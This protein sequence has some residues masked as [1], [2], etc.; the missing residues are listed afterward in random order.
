M[1]ELEQ[2]IVDALSSANDD[3]V[4]ESEMSRC[5]W[6]EYKGVSFDAYIVFD[7]K[8]VD[9]EQQF[10]WGW[11]VTG[12]HTEYGSITKIEVNC[13]DEEKDEDLSG[14]VDV[15]VIERNIRLL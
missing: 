12:W 11:S 6:G 1:N 3:E 10:D 2:H 14:L 5:V 4:S 8:K 15:D 9:E 7:A 13:W